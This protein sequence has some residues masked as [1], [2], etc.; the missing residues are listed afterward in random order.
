MSITDESS[1]TNR[2]PDT[3]LDYIPDPPQGRMAYKRGLARSYASDEAV[4]PPMYALLKVTERCSSHCAYCAHAGNT[5]RTGEPEQADLEDVLRQIAE[6]GATSLNLTGGEPLLRDDIFALS[7]YA[8]DRGLFPILLTNGIPLRQRVEEL[9][10]GGLGMVIVSVDSIYPE[11]YRKT[12]GSNLS[13]VLDGIDALLELGDQCPTVTVTSVITHHNLDQIEETIAYFA[14]R[15]IGV[16]LTPYHHYGRW[17]DDQLTPRDVQKYVKV[18]EAIKRLKDQDAGVINSHAYLDN[19]VDFTF[20]NRTMP[21]SFA[22]CSGVTTLYIDSMLNVRSCW[23]HG[24]PVAGNL[25]E[26]RLQ[27]LLA[28]TRMK[29][30]R[31][32]IRKLQCERCWLLCTAEISLRW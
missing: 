22:C 19:F 32:R 12:R 7:R 5:D 11:S 16:E 20:K 15:N 30:T 25:K 1:F 6:V 17:E 27:D 18:I 31:R 13:H 29:E 4:V 2:F 24:L 3:F 26:H 23:S 28:S 21:D 9:A 8:R 10:E 14:E